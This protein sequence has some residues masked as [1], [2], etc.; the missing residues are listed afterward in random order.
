MGEVLT[1]VGIDIG[2]TTTQLIF[3]QLVLDDR[4]AMSSAPSVSVVE[5]RVIYR[6][7]IHFTPLLSPTEIDARAVRR[8]VEE[9]YRLAGVDP[10]EVN[11]GAVII[12]GDTAR[13]ENAQAV[14]ES[15]EGMAGDFVV[16]TAGSDLEAIL[17]GKGSGAEALSRREGSTV[18]NLDV[19]GGT[20]NVAVF[21]EGHVV[22]TSCLNVGG[23]LVRLSQD[24]TVEHVSDLIS[25]V[26]DHLGL[27]IRA[28]DR[29]EPK[30][31]ESICGRMASLCDE[32]L[33]LVPRTSLLD[34][35]LTSHDLKDPRR[36]LDRI[37]ISGGVGD[38]IHQGVWDDPYRY[39]DLGVLLARAMMGTRM[40]ALGKVVPPEETI[41]ATVVGAG[42][43]SMEL[44]GSTIGFSHDGV[45]P[46]RNLPILRVSEAEEAH[47]LPQALRERLG[48]FMDSAGEQMR[49]A[50]ALK[51]LSNPSFEEVQ[52]LAEEILEGL[53]DYPVRSGLLVLVVERDMGKAL[54]YALSS[55]LPRDVR[56][57]SVDGVRVENGDY[58][59]IGRPLARGRVLPVVIK[60]LVFGA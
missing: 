21:R 49:V 41:R 57:V 37:T 1:S 27:R 34:R 47:C 39:G 43:H 20:T 14:L 55:R 5:K 23:R 51:G 17:A 30:V 3:S 24:G 58:V 26:L 38:C 53:G 6:S 12:T 10:R 7:R 52:R 11:A 18:A 35:M 50:L 44:S 33:G 48:W 46:L 2:T 25:P 28:G 36:E 9:E 59:D 22:D 29:L 15:V 19:G 32:L 16:A 45:F 56:V 31:A 60:T 13:K 8:L 54:G 4:A 42:S 40:F